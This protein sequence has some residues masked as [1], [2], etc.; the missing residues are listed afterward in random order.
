MANTGIITLGNYIL[1]FDS[2]Y[3]VFKYDVQP[4]L[5]YEIKCITSGFLRF[6]TWRYIHYNYIIKVFTTRYVHIVEEKKP[7]SE[8]KIY[9]LYGIR[10]K[11]E[12]YCYYYYLQNEVKCYFESL[13]T[14]TPLLLKNY[15]YNHWERIPNLIS[16]EFYIWS[17]YPID[18]K[19]IEIFIHD[20]TNDRLIVYS[21]I[22]DKDKFKIEKIKEKIY[23]V[24]LEVDVFFENGTELDI[25]ISL[26]DIKGNYLKDGLW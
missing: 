22:T 16:P 12:R 2:R 20:K 13:F 4:E 19:S 6:N 10:Y 18:E 25:Y 8:K 24:S 15:K 5:K 21:Y 14:Q 7:Y 11:D 9:M 3:C 23:K 26:Y 17:Y 1:G